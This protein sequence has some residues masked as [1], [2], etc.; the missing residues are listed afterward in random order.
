[1]IVNLCWKFYGII[2]TLLLVFCTHDVWTEKIWPE[3]RLPQP[4]AVSYEEN[5]QTNPRLP[6]FI[7]LVVSESST[8]GGER[9]FQI[10]R[11]KLLES[12]N[13]F[14]LFLEF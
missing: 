12:Y 14:R 11:T 13:F 7:V 4:D 8:C 9:R 5:L 10:A 1:M 6:Y 2:F 3:I